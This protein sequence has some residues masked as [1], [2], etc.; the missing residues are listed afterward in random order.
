MSKR[1]KL[2]RCPFCGSV[3]T[4]ESHQF[5]GSY[6]IRCKGCNVTTPSNSDIGIIAKLWNRRAGE[7]H[8]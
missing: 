5:Y 4:I 3:V 6:Y 8:E 2:K 1:I 7:H